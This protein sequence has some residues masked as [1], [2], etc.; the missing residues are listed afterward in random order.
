MGTMSAPLTPAPLPEL[1]YSR[2]RFEPPIEGVEHNEWTLRRATWTE[3]LVVNGVTGAELAIPRRYLGRM[4]ET[5]EA[6]RGV[7]LLEDLEVAGGRARP[8]RRGVI[9]MPPRRGDRHTPPWQRHRAPGTAAQ[10]TAIRVE[11]GPTSLMKR[12]W[13]GSVALGFVACIATLFAMS[14]TSRAALPF[15]PADDY[16][17]VVNRMGTPSMD[18][19]Q[20]DPRG[21]GYR[22]LVYPRRQITVILAGPSQS[23]ARYAGAL[24]RK[25][26]VIHAAD[27]AVMERAAGPVLR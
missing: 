12:A 23:E 21:G 10:V 7:R 2:F 27:P 13:R 25:G 19:W 15:T 5:E 4:F 22:R 3:M 24:N 11:H 20:P 6:I 17:D 8:I 14:W 18:A 9:E 16:S 26:R 1:A